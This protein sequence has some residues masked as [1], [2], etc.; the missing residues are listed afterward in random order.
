MLH[1]D[2]FL[3]KA[4]AIVYATLLDEGTYHCSIRTMYRI[5]QDLQGPK[6]KSCCKSLLA[7]QLRCCE[8]RVAH[9]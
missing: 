9:Y 1:A 7:K 6:N 2:R 8:Y 3:D 5:W 4:P